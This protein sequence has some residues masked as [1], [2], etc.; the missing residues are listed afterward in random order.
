MSGGR[1]GPSDTLVLFGATGD[2]VR[3][4]LFGSILGLCVSGRFGAA[5]V[6]GVARRGKRELKGVPGEWELYAVARV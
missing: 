2:L 6:V 1:P 5:P 3:K 4:K